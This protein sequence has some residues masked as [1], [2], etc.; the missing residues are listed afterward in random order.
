VLK[1]QFKMEIVCCETSETVQ[2][3]NGNWGTIKNTFKRMGVD[4]NELKDSRCDEGYV[5]DGKH[6]FYITRNRKY[7]YDNDLY[8]MVRYNEMDTC[9]PLY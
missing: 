3:V 9:Y 6:A 8:T 2:V 7:F 5:T 4:T 1:G